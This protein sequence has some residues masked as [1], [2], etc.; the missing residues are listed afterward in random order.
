M[1]LGDSVIE[2]VLES[3]TMNTTL[4]D[5]VKEE[6]KGLIIIFNK[7]FPNISLKNLEERLKGLKVE[8]SSKFVSKRIFS[9]SPMTNTLSFNMEE[10]EKN[11][12]SR[13]VMMSALLT[14]M[15]AHDNTYGFDQDNKLITFNTGY[16]EILSNFLVGNESEL[17]LFDDE[18]I[19]TNLI[20]EV[21]GNDTLF[22]AY[23][24]N[25]PKLVM[26]AIL[27]EGDGL[28]GTSNQ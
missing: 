24:S 16:T 20:A 1:I 3:L 18:V 9:Y 12:D 26:D 13:H 25:N 15:T 14:I 28:D 19:A 5:N 17:S 23:F 7:F 8:K 22:E 4:D 2:S 21:I 27:K 11:Y 6:I 10:L